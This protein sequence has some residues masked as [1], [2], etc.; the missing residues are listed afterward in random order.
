MEP[1]P[2]FA[3]PL[4]ASAAPGPG[5]AQ[6]AGPALASEAREQVQQAFLERFEAL[7]PRIQKEWPEVARSSLEATRGSL[8]HVVEAISRQTGI[9]SL[10]V[11]TQLLDLLQVTVEQAQQMGESLRPLEQQL[12]ELLDDLNATLRPRIEKPVRERPLLA[13]GVAAGVGLLL[14]MLLSGRRS[15]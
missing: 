12:E 13:L 5:S 10:G 7:L 14:G 1:T 11:R 15:T 8:D 9:T 4:E 6:D 2:P 3:D